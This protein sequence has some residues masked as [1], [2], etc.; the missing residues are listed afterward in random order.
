MSR[1]RAAITEETIARIAG[2]ILSG[3]DYRVRDDAS[4]EKAVRR[5]VKMARAIVSEVY[6]TEPLDGPTEPE[7]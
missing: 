1:T 3:Y 4:D 6:R 5:A 2:N 7:P